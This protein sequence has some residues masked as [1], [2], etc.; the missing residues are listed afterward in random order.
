MKDFSE[1]EHAVKYRGGEGTYI[2]VTEDAVK[3]SY[4]PLEGYSGP[5]AFP[6]IS[7]E[8]GKI[9]ER[10]REPI[11]RS[12]REAGVENEDIHDFFEAVGVFNVP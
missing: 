1:L 4:D 5:V 2:M 11:E 9:F 8:D 10:D 3:A 6:V 12:L 7:L